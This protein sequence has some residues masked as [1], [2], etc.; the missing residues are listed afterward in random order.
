[1][2]TNNLARFRGKTSLVCPPSFS[3]IIVLITLGL[4]SLLSIFGSNFIHE[5]YK[6]SISEITPEISA[7][8]QF[9]LKRDALWVR[10]RPS[11]S[12]TQNIRGSI[13]GEDSTL[14][15]IGAP[16][17]VADHH[18]VKVRRSGWVV[19]RSGEREYLRRVGPRRWKVNP[20]HEYMT[21]RG[22]LSTSSPEL[23]RLF[24]FSGH[25]YRAKQTKTIGAKLWIQVDL[26]G[27]CP[28]YSHVE[29]F[30]AAYHQRPVAPSS[31]DRDLEREADLDNPDHVIACG[32]GRLNLH[33]GKTRNSLYEAALARREIPISNDTNYGAK[34]PLIV[35]GAQLRYRPEVFHWAQW[36]VDEAAK[37]QTQATGVPVRGEV[38]VSG[39]VDLTIGGKTYR[40]NKRGISSCLHMELYSVNILPHVDYWISPAGLAEQERLFRGFANGVKSPVH[41]FHP[42]SGAGNGVGSGA[43]HAGNSEVSL[44]ELLFAS[45][46]AD[47]GAKHRDLETAKKETAFFQKPGD[48]IAKLEGVAA[49]A[50]T[51]QGD[52]YQGAPEFFGLNP[53]ANS[54]IWPRLSQVLREEGVRV[55]RRLAWEYI[56]G[57]ATADGFRSAIREVDEVLVGLHHHRGRLGAI[58]VL[59]RFLDSPETSVASLIA[60]MEARILRSHTW[61]RDWMW[62]R[63]WQERHRHEPRLGIPRKL[64]QRFDEGLKNRWLLEAKVMSLA[65]MKG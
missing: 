22:G 53:K 30:I 35:V 40:A 8:C 45:M 51:P 49:I 57:L 48:L 28:C 26:E 60:A 44:S 5:S 31:F 13:N 33:V 16:I 7:Q 15:V 59:Q 55:G 20:D 21:L 58:E 46:V 1:M 34:N 2:N 25:S 41:L 4:A 39:K 56:A 18:W 47:F 54:D 32:K 3:L 65:A 50:M 14:E 43:A 61:Q 37:A 9:Q 12:G 10:N 11:L 64:R 42:H 23:G 38:R 17:Y 6:L 27:Y 63:L 36:V 24:S 62:A 29:E 19:A 52:L